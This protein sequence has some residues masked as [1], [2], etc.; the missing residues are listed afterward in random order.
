[1]KTSSVEF[2]SRSPTP[3]PMERNYRRFSL[4]ILYGRTAA[5]SV[6]SGWPIVP[7][8]SSLRI[9]R[10]SKSKLKTLGH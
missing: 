8:P 5:D 2:I 1:M 3:S 9:R 4:L 6:Q 10:R 7:K